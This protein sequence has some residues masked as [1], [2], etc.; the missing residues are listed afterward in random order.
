[1]HQWSTRQTIPLQYSKKLFF[2]SQIL[3]VSLSIAAVPLASLF[4]PCL[5]VCVPPLQACCLS[6]RCLTERWP[7][8]ALSLNASISLSPFRSHHPRNGGSI[9]HDPRTHT[10]LHYPCTQPNAFRSHSEDP[11]NLCALAHV[12]MCVNCLH[13]CVCA[14]MRDFPSLTKDNKSSKYS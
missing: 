6:I 1:M 10:V 5:Q 8:A 11:S 3:S 2:V 4:F 7:G 14:C 12:C 13:G 9:R